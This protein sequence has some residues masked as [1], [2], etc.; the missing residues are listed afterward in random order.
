MLHFD[1]GVVLQNLP[2][3]LT[4]VVVTIQIAILSMALA[5]ALGLVV[6]IART[7]GG[8]PVDRLLGLPVDMLRSI[9]LLAL[10]V[11]VFYALP[12]LSG[13]ELSPFTAGVVSLGLQYGAFMSEV[14]RAGFGSISPGQRIAGLALGMTNAQML[15]RVVVPQAAIRMLPPA[16]SQMASLIKDTSLMYAIG[17]TELMNQAATVNGLYARPFEIFTVVGI[18]Y[19]CITYPVMYVINWAYV[20]LSP[21]VAG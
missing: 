2:F 3:L 16:A 14:F 1:F 17:V 15:R 4:G 6:G 12:V 7:Y 20:R 11:W 5:T 8:P 19:F 10:M 21:L 13:L 9:P 18:I